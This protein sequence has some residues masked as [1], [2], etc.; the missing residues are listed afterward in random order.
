MIR[1]ID[2]VPPSPA[3]TPLRMPRWPFPILL[4]LIVVGSWALD[5]RQPMP[6]PEAATPWFTQVRALAPA[7][8]GMDRVN[9]QAALTPDVPLGS[10]LVLLAVAACTLATLLAIGVRAP[11][12]LAVALGLAATR[13]LWS[14]VSPGQDALPWW[15]VPSW[16]SRGRR[17]AE[18]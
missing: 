3:L 1:M 5:T 10:L 15:R 17:R 18:S 13:S 14:T 2:L 8:W 12:A 9:A 11:L 7:T 16:P 4:T 6:W